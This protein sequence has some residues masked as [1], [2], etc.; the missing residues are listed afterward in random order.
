MTGNLDLGRNSI[1]NLRDPA[2][3]SDACTKGYV[4]RS[5]NTLTTEVNLLTAS[6]IQFHGAKSNIHMHNHRIHD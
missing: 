1:K 5:V 6:N 4:D 2:L 3:G